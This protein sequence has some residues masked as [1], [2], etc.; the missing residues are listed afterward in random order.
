MMKLKVCRVLFSRLAGVLLAAC[1][2]APLHAAT[3]SQPAISYTVVFHASA[4]GATVSQTFRYGKK[5]ALRANTFRK[6]GCF[7]IGWSRTVNGAVAYTDGQVVHNLASTS[8][9]KVHLY[10]QWAVRKYIVRF[11]ANGGTGKI[12]DQLF[13][14]GKAMPLR[15]NAF[16]RKGYAF[17]GWAKSAKAKKATYKNRKAVKNLSKR[18]GVIVLYAV[19]NKLGKKNVVLCL[20]DSITKGIRCEGLPY[21]T[22]LAKLSGRKVVNYGNGGKTSAYGVSIAKKALI[23][24]GPGTVCILFGANDAVQ[25]VHHRDV[26]E[27]LRQIIRLCRKYAATPVIA[28]PTPQI[29]DHARYNANV[30]LLAADVRALGREEHVAVVDLNMA[31][32][33]GKKYINPLDGLH[34][35]D[36]GGDLIANMFYKAIR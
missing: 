10:A 12:A 36:A 23:A 5:K 7:F 2:V 31:F 33:N 25:N 32:G 11:N 28:T 24:E 22:R 29:W 18:G 1:A 17:L 35:S 30:K 16:K 3:P 6:E 13:A 20:G 21:P 14:Y 27:N 34:L 26:K 19:W 8:G 4:K 15:A 9:A